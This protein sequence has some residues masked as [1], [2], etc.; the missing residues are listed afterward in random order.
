LGLRWHEAGLDPSWGVEIAARAVAGQYRVARSL[1]E[2]PT[3]GFTTWDVRGY[4]QPHDCLLLVAGVEN[5]TNRNYREH[6]DF[7]AENGNAMYQP[8]INFY[9]GT[10]LKY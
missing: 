1:F 4:W 2:T 9:C 8:G 6:L 3:A 7:R 10:E 5:F